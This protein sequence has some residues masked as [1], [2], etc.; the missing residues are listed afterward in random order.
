MYTQHE[1]NEHFATMKRTAG[2]TVTFALFAVIATAATTL[3]AVSP[4]RAGDLREAS[5][6]FMPVA[7]MPA[8]A[9]N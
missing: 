2:E 3:F 5:L 9:P 7:Q 6:A 1:K 4:A 8:Q